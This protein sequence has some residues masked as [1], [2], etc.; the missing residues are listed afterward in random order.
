MF[1]EGYSFAASAQAVEVAT[2]AFFTAIREME[3][4]DRP[5]DLEYL[6]RL[7]EFVLDAHAHERG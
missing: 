3:T 1:P 5:V 7:A 4:G 2:L 6:I